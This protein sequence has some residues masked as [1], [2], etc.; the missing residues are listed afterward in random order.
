M[1]IDEIKIL[2]QK[3]LSPKR[4]THAIN[5][6]KAA[7]M[8]AERYG[9]DRDKAA[10]A[11]LV[12]DCA[13]G[14]SG[15]EIFRLCKKYDIIVDEIMQIQPELL[16]GVLGSYLAAELFGINCPV[17]LDAVAGHTMGRDGMDKVTC[18]V[19]IADYIEEGRN[20]P[21]VEIIRRAAEESLEKAVIA[22]I[23]NTISH[24]LAKGALLHPQTV[25]TRNWALRQL[26]KQEI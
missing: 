21:G 12:H 1:N 4:Y 7:I 20:Y 3:M 5:V 25:A 18:I 15:D 13:K 11:G 10:L 9:A 2:L 6:M 26:L 22:A 23:D 8:L 17:V 16:H 24:I 19:F 14:I